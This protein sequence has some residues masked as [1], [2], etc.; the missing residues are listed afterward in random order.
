[1]SIGNSKSKGRAAN[2]IDTEQESRIDEVQQEGTD[3][4]AIT[5]GMSTGVPEQHTSIAYRPPV[6]VT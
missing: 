5:H 4:S 6:N 3:E 1:M 2:P